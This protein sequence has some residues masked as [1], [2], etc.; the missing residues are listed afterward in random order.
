MTE[1]TVDVIIP[2]HTALRPISRAVA[3]VLTG[4]TADVRVRVICHDVAIAS[5]GAALGSW[6][7]DERVHLT[8]HRDGV[9]SPA[10]PLNRG[11]AEA[12]A[13]FTTL[14]DS[15]DEYEPGAI[16]AWLSV[17]QRD[18][19][20]VV[21]Q[22]LRHAN[23]ASTRTPPTRPFRRRRLDGVRDRLAYRTRQHGLVRRSRFP[24]LRMT[25][26]VRTGEDV[27]QGVHL[28]YSGARI[29]FAKGTPAYVI[30]ADQPER[31]SVSPKS[32]A[33]SLEFLD[34]IA[35]DG[36]AAWL[37]EAQRE[38]LAIKILRTHVM[39][40]L[41]ASLKAGNYPGD[42]G[43]LG[44]AVQRLTTMAP[45]AMS[46]MSRQ[47]VR[48]LRAL[49]DGTDQVVLKRELARATDFHRPASVMSSS[50]RHILH[51]EAMPR[52]L[53]AVALTP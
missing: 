7:G 38:A 53:A 52:F 22:P 17:Q 8:E 47:E 42:K 33:V 20:D 39:D 27:I 40:V 31:A 32:A 41:A 21:I 23:G 44:E 29:S 50:L 28:W 19:A 1:P 11:Y 30:H 45:R 35:G 43:A 51:R 9:P 48:V 14:L 3:S 2:I 6:E 46:I 36:A 25:P 12:T 26:G 18:D 37:T 10:G 4:T 24:D 15:D 49:R 16:D 13:E 5:I 34:A